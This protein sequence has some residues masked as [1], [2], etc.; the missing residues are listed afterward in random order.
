MISC[1]SGLSLP[2]LRRIASGIAI[3]PTSCKKRSAGDDA[4]VVVRQFHGPCDGDG[5][6]GHALGVAFGF[7]ILQVERVTQCLQ[8][9]VIGALQVGQ[10]ATKHLGAGR[11][12]RLQLGLVGQVFLLQTAIFH[13]PANDGQQLFA[14]EGFQQ[15]V[16]G[17][18]SNGSQGDGDVV[19]GSDHHHRNVRMFLPDPRQQ[20]QAV[21]P[22]HDQVGQHH[23]VAVVGMKQDKRLRPRRDGTT[24]ETCLLQNGAHDFPNCVLVV[25]YQNAFIGHRGTLFGNGAHGRSFDFIHFGQDGQINVSSNSIG[26]IVRVH[27]P[28]SRRGRKSYIPQLANVGIANANLRQ[29]EAKS[30]PY[31]KSIRP[32]PSAVAEFDRPTSSARSYPLVSM[33]LVAFITFA[34]LMVDEFG[35]HDCSVLRCDEQIAKRS[36]LTAGRRSKR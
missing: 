17:A 25:D 9:D 32:L 7:G 16:V 6:G 33:I 27:E 20:G 12:Q 18:V 2:G 26:V 36:K 29:R 21:H 4:N 23:G 3:L 31:G 15:I 22:F 19:D 35:H 30:S 10:S 1:S 24:L 14:L 13:G 34:V 28:L 8:G 11:H 5:E